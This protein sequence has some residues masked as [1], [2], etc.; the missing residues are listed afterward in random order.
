MELDNAEGKN[1]CRH[2]DFDVS[3]VSDQKRLQVT[4]YIADATPINTGLLP[5]DWYLSLVLAGAEQH[6]LP[7][8]YIKALRAFATKPDPEQGRQS[9]TLA[10]SCLKDAGF[11]AEPRR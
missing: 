8:A 5:Y 4:T 10:H 3:R 9:K 11:S 7:P 1:Y 6:R 2:D